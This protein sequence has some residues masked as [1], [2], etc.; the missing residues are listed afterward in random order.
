MIS[1]HWIALRKE[2]WSRLETLVQQVDRGLGVGQAV[3]DISC[4]GDPEALAAFAWFVLQLGHGDR[5]VVEPSETVAD[6]DRRGVVGVVEDRRCAVC[7]AGGAAALA[8]MGFVDV[9]DEVYATSA[10]AMNASYFLAHQPDSGIRVY[11][12]HCTTRAFFNP[13]RFWK[14]IDVDYLFE[15]VVTTEKPLNVSRVLSGRPR[16]FVAVSTGTNE[17]S[18]AAQVPGVKPSTA[19]FLACVQTAGSALRQKFCNNP[20]SAVCSEES[21]NESVGCRPSSKPGYICVM[22]SC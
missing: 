14:V 17:R 16:L 10:G 13:L 21:G 8:H 15:R 2:S 19:V 5:R 9:F 18:H 3:R 12:E 7:S 22:T 6:E 4:A 11:F 20:Q 1:N